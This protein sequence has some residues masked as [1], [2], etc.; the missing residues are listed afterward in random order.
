MIGVGDFVDGGV[1]FECHDCRLDH[2][3]CSVSEDVSA[4][5]LAVC[6]VGDEFDQ[7]VGVAVDE[8]SWYDVEWEHRGDDGSSL[9]FGLLFGDSD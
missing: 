5:E 6:F 2:I 9:A 4:E 3:P 1:V 8:G 7:T